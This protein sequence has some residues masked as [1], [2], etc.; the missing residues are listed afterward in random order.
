MILSAAAHFS[1]NSGRC[2]NEVQRIALGV[3]DAGI[4]SIAL[5]LIALIEA[6]IGKRVKI[7]I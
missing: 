6:L 2:G 7:L 4:A 5:K 1:E 3:L